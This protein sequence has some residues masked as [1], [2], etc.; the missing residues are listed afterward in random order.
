MSEH[1]YLSWVSN[2]DL[3]LKP[4]LISGLSV[5]CVPLD[6]TCDSSYV[7]EDKI[8]FPGLSAFHTLCVTSRHWQISPVEMRGRKKAIQTFTCDYGTQWYQCTIVPW[9][10]FQSRYWG[11]CWVFSFL[12]SHLILMI[13]SFKM[14]LISFFPSIS[15]ITPL[16]RVLC[17]ICLKYFNCLLF[18]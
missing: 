9:L 5:D 12:H 3:C 15:A 11:C 4:C 1:Q 6:F 10:A 16:V 7:V 13:I 17:T 18:I 8:I 14:P 2:T